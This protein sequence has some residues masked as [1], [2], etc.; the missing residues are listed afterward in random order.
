M[1][2]ILFFLLLFLF[3]FFQLFGQ[4]NIHRLIGIK[5]EAFLLLLL[6][7]Y[8]FYGQ[9]GDCSEKAFFFLF[10]FRRK[11]TATATL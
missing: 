6:N 1:C 5:R 11:N 2:G 7:F 10:S 8:D 3:L 9:D 4:V